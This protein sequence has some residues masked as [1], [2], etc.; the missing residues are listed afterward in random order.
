VTRW[1][2]WGGADVTSVEG[3]VARV[4]A[5]AA[6]GLDAIW[7]PQTAALDALTALAV[8][9][10]DVPGI[11]LGTAVVPI[12]G[13][14]PIPLAQQALTVADAVGPDRLTL[15]I[16]VTH[17]PVSEGWYGIPYGQV[18]ALCREELEALHGLL[19]P[20][21]RAHVEG[22][23]LTARLAL[24]LHG[25]APGLVVAAL[26]PKM[27]E[28]AGRF[29]DGTVTWMTGPRTLARS[30]VPALR[31]AAAAA[32]RPAPRVVVG[33]PVCVTSDPAGAR[34]RLSPAMA[35][36]AQMASYRRMVAAEGVAAPVDLA[37]VGDD[38]EVRERLEGLVAAGAT[39]VLANVVGDDD[40]RAR[41][42]ALLRTLVAGG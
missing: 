39:E 11:D 6:D 1:A 26:G 2:V 41:T 10:R 35:G 33:L 32:G 23:H 27:L 21:R 40:E 37:L 22:E 20:D 28:L 30:V 12:Q 7:F 17:A 13:R 16:G 8:A 34:E 38:D 29:A 36:S 19:G 42:R 18:V 14:H 25:P 15:G 4:R 31:D 5:A 24:S 9:G 3:V